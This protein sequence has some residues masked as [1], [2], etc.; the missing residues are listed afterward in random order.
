[1]RLTPDQRID[2]KR[3]EVLLKRGSR[4]TSTESQLSRKLLF[5]KTDQVVGPIQANILYMP[6]MHN[7]NEHMLSVGLWEIPR[8]E[9]SIVLL[10][11]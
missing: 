10:Q 5:D 8:R 11:P 6:V 1:M 4:R 2:Q 9:Q 3:V 7:T